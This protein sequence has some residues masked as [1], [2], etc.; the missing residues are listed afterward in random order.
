[1]ADRSKRPSILATVTLVA[2]SAIVTACTQ[3]SEPGRVPGPSE[4]CALNR[5]VDG[6]GVRLN[7]GPDRENLNVRLQCIDA[8][9]TDQPPWGERA[10]SRLRDLVGPEVGLR[11]V[12]IDRYGRT[13]GRIYRNGEDLSLRLVYEGKA[14]VYPR[15]CDD[16][17]YYD[18]ERLAR[19]AAR[20]IW[21]KPG[22]HQEPW[23][24]RRV[25]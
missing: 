9:E 18:A 7:C 10:T 13:V 19:H 4:T 20:G 16:P 24:W 22:L 25:R 8:P 14:A 11:S 5:V 23:R 6:D 1:M 2:L 21:A 12:D 3:M 17:A 15:Y